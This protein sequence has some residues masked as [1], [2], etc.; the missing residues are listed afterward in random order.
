[1]IKL[2]D[3]MDIALKKV[4]EQ[5][6]L[7]VTINKKEY[8]LLNYRGCL[9]LTESHCP[10][11]QHPLKECKFNGF[12][13]IICPLHEYR[14]NIKTGEESAGRCGPLSV[15]PVKVNDLGLFVEIP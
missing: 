4:P 3:N 2:F 11:M 12:N 8:L 9:T 7:K 6:V 14:F 5:K 15:F 13:E 10:H 1:M